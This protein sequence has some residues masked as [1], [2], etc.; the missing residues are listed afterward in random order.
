MSIAVVGL[1][2][3]TAPVAVRERLAF[4]EPALA[5]PLEQFFAP[6]VDEVVM[7]S[8]CNRVEIYMHTRQSEAGVRQSIAF[9]ETYHGVPASQFAP[10]LYQFYDAEAVQH[11]FRVAASLDSL[12]VG[13]PQI[14]GQVKTAYAAAQTAGRTGTILNQ[15]F[16]RALN[17]A[18]A[19]RSETGIGDHAISV[20]YAAVQLA[21]KIFEHFHDRAALVLGAGETSEL[22]ARHL[23]RQGV[24]T[25]FVA[26]RTAARAEKLAQ[27][28]HAKAIPWQAFPDYLVHADIV[29]SSTS[30]PHPIIHQAMVREVMRG[31][32]GRP[33]FFIDTA[34]PRD[35]DP[36]VNS[37]DDVFLYDIDDL[38]HV[39]EANRR[40]RQH[41]ARTAE[42]L[43][44]REVR[45][46]Q[47]WLGALDAVPTI[48][49]LR[50]RAETVRLDELDKALAKLGTL[51]ER[52]R[53]IVEAL[54][55]GIV[56][57]L[58]HLPTVNLKRVSHDGQVRDYVQMIRHLFELD[59]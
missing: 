8:T 51:S 25:M 14:L 57:K 49:A 58:L 44:E 17:V 5:D 53:R 2:H 24:A 21:K 59:A 30:A 36:S 45:H 27:A 48:V 11:L 20:S 41:E 37:L 3:K 28:L 56:N 39:I 10:Y 38:E 31:R 32:R 12:V 22:A 9:L 16:A 47:Q 52:E 54:T 34:V 50:Q 26:N 18:K 43:V 35:I 29:M 15:L 1:N 23:I 55:V 40:E 19:V 42:E 6:A 46:F 4:A 13:E 33:M 7:L